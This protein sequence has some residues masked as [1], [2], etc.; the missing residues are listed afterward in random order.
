MDEF[1]ELNQPVRKNAYSIPVPSNL[2]LKLRKEFEKKYESKQRYLMKKFSDDWFRLLEEQPPADQTVRDFF[3]EKHNTH[4]LWF[5]NGLCKILLNCQYTELDESLTQVQSASL[6]TP[7]HNL[8]NQQTNKSSDTSSKQPTFPVDFYAY[9]PSSWVGREELLQKLSEKI[10]GSCRLLLIV[11]ITGI[12]KTALSE[13][14]ASV[15]LVNWLEGDWKNRF[16]RENFDYEGKATDFASVATE[17]LEEWGEKVPTGDNK[18]ELLLQ[19]LTEHLCN[20]QVLVLID[21]LERLLTGNQ[22]DGWGDFADEWWR[23][24]FL[25]LLSAKSCKSRLIIT[26][27]DLPVVLID[28]RYS[29]SW[30]RQELYGLEESEQEAFFKKTGLDVSSDPVNK[31]FLLRIG[32]AYMGHPLVLKVIAGEINQTFDKNVEAYW[33]D[34]GDKIKQI[35]RILAEAERGNTLGKKDSLQ[36]HNLTYQLQNQ[37]NKRLEAAFSRLQKDVPDAYLLICVASVYR[38]PEQKEAW[39]MQLEGLVDGECSKERQ[40]KAL[41]ELMNRFFVEISVNHNN[42]RLL[43]QHNLIRSLALAHYEQ[44]LKELHSPEAETNLA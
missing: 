16:K 15:E 11:G 36:L 44:I 34:Y 28:S 17:W 40:E 14:L 12:G 26:S 18:S 21:S 39:L 30:Y 8:V 27:Q 4:E 5:I 38:T 7:E 41:N 10:G 31:S 1:P 6:E 19:K 9:E 32:K 33:N 35:E 29:I 24:F 3:D 13:R 42:K 20:N 43:G 23:K 2:R 37:V 22:Q 25:S